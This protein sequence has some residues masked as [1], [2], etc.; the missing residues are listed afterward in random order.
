VR[1]LVFTAFP[2]LSHPCLADSKEQAPSPPAAGEINDLFGYGK[3]QWSIAAGYGFGVGLLGSND[4][5]LKEI[6]YA[7]VIPRWGIGLGDPLAVSS[8]YEGNFDLLVEAPMLFE[9]HPEHGFAGG[10]TL[11]LRYNFLQLERVVPFIEGGAGVLGTD[12][13]LKEQADGFNFS[14]QAGLGFHFFV[15]PRVAIT[16]ESRF[17]HISN[18][19]LRNPNS[20]INDCLFLIG[21]SFF[22][23]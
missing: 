3:Q 4:G 7:T 23:R 20:G 11:M 14:L 15:L 8:W 19:G 12:L 17:H 16:A 10:G 13:D 2:L 18:A 21:T 1:A 6:R 22:V 5:N 9:Y